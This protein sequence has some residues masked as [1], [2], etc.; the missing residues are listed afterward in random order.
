MNSTARSEATPASELAFH[1]TFED[2]HSLGDRY[3]KV[4]ARLGRVEGTDSFRNLSEH[5]RWGDA[6]YLFA[7]LVID[8]QLDVNGAREGQDPYGYR[9][10]FD[11]VGHVNRE[12]VEAMLAAF[13][14][15]DRGLERLDR[16][17]GSPK[18]FSDYV[19]RVADVLGVKRFCEMTT[20][21]SRFYTDSG[22]R[23]YGVDVFQ[24]RVADRVA[25][26]REAVTVAA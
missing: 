21:E 5:D 8:C 19:A 26:F 14:R 17:F 11:H 25:K 23:W 3:L 6:N 18:G 12:R 1:V 24:Y 4:Y 20:P 9:V 15:I 7:D 22:F 13:R 2:K 10:E 16:R